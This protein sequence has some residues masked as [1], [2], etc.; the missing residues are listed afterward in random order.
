MPETHLI[1]TGPRK[2]QCV[3]CA[4]LKK[5]IIKLLLLSV[6]DM[7]STPECSFDSVQAGQLKL[8]VLTVSDSCLHSLLSLC[9]WPSLQ[10]EREAIPLHTILI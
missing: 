9:L 6:F 5:I 7:T 10:F 2:M 3:S 8:S 1:T 4:F